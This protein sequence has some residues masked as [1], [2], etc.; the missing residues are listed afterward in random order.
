M[1][2]EFSIIYIQIKQ[3]CNQYVFIVNFDIIH[4]PLEYQLICLLKCWILYKKNVYD[5]QINIRVFPKFLPRYAMNDY[6]KKR[7]KFMEHTNTIIYYIIGLY[8][9]TYKTTL[10]IQS[11][12]NNKQTIIYHNSKHDSMKTLSYTI[13]L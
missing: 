4:W 5:R 12:W 1:E 3:R 11:L 8:S 9:I 7:K 10:T 13:L 6:E 2:S